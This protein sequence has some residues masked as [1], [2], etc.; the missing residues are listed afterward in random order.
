MAS[1]SRARSRMRRRAWGNARPADCGSASAR[2][3]ALARRRDRRCQRSSQLRR[4]LPE[5]REILRARVPKRRDDFVLCRLLRRMRHE[6]HRLAAAGDDVGLEPLQIL[7][8]FVRFRHRPGRVLQQDRA[9]PLEP[10]QTLTL[11]GECL[12]GSW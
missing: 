6:H 9:D 8:G 4:V 7:A 11:A 5:F 10:A 2:P 3:E 12:D 1:S